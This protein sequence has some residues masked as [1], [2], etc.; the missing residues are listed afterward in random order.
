MA[1]LANIRLGGQ[2]KWLMVA[3]PILYSSNHTLRFPGNLVFK[4]SKSM[5]INGQTCLNT[6]A[7]RH[8]PDE[9]KLITY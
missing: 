2:I 4:Y 3:A 1:L 5:Y 6:L 9:L 7:K 8:S